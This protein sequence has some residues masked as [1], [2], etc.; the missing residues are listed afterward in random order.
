MHGEKSKVTS[1]TSENKRNNYLTFRYPPTGG[2]SCTG[3]KFV[4]LT[5]IFDLISLPVTLSLLDLHR[6]LAL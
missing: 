3:G 4:G 6:Q 2:I 1:R 5:L